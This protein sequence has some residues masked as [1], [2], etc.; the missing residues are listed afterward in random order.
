MG[1]AGRPLDTGR[2]AAPGTEIRVGDFTEL[3]A[4]AIS[5]VD[6]REDL[7]ASAPAS[8]LPRMKSVGGWCAIFMTGLSSGSSIPSSR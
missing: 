4:T 8:W 1:R 3:I 6:A 7:A 2:P 5:N